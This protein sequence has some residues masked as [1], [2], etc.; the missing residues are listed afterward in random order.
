M[1]IVV[2]KFFCLWWKECVVF[3]LKITIIFKNFN[4]C[5]LQ[6][7][8]KSIVT[9]LIKLLLLA[10]HRLNIL[11]YDWKLIWK[12]IKLFGNLYRCHDLP[13][14]HPIR[15]WTKNTQLRKSIR[16]G[17][18]MDMCLLLKIHLCIWMIAFS[19]DIWF[20]FNVLFKTIWNRW[21]E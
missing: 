11:V 2:D 18:I 5:R 16:R 7:F 8:E 15:T 10:T 14:L 17:L 12:R 3:L 6:G 19:S 9:K 4:Q 13:R 20:R 21:S 1:L